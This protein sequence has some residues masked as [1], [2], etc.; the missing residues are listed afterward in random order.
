[1][2]RMLGGPIFTNIFGNRHCIKGS[3]NLIHFLEIYV[4]HIEIIHVEIFFIYVN[5]SNDD[6]NH[7]TS[8]NYCRINRT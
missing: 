5:G 8:S 7:S 1:M 6:E 3:K 4:L 2:T